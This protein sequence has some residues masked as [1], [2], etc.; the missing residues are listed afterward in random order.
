MTCIVGIEHEGGVLIG[1][2]SAGVSG[3]D[4]ML[5][6]DAKVFR[7]G[8]AI[9]GFTSSFRMGQLLRYSLKVPTGF[10]RNTDRY[11]AT[12]F[13]CAVRKCL[14][15]GGY[16]RKK[17]GEETGGTFLVGIVGK[18]Y[19]IEDDFQMG[20]T[21]GGIDAVGCGAS[22]AMGAMFVARGKPQHRAEVG[23]RAAVAFS[24]GV[25]PPFVFESL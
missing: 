14:G 18:L 17:E 23:L 3:L 4:M 22:Y 2:D 10:V 15:D 16:A 12:K 9:F 25:R 19:R 13:I 1:G 20:R 7:N 5:R 8:P 11:M 6:A 24:G 21:M